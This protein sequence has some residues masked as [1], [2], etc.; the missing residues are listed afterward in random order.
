MLGMMAAGTIIHHVI[1][2]NMK[3]SIA[4]FVLTASLVCAASA[5]AQGK[6]DKGG[7]SLVKEVL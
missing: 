6:L 5:L 7:C 3:R 2:G 4:A 1:G